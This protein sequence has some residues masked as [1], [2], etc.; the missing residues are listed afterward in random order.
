MQVF[1]WKR[2]G[3]VDVYAFNTDAQQEHLALLVYGA[4]FANS[5]PKD[6]SDIADIYDSTNMSFRS[7]IDAMLDV[8]GVEFDNAAFEYGTGFT[9]LKE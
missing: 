4:A 2:Y 5:Y 1:V 9:T 8:Y 3:S 7:K 6:K